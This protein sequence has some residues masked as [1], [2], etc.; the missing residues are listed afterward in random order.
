[1]RL[2]RTCALTALLGACGTSE[3]QTTPPPAA[4]PLVAWVT[5]LAART[6]DDATPDTV[7][8]KNI[9]D[10]DDGAAFDGFLQSPGG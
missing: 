9:E 5:E 1:M 2:L 6:T 10:T 7:E 3:P 8:D 4:I